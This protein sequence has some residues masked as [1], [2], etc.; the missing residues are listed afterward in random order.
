MKIVIVSAQIWKHI[1]QIYTLFFFF[2]SKFQWILFMMFEFTLALQNLN[3]GD[4][5]VTNLFDL[6]FIITL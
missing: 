1:C 3:F 6:C 2:F 5:R 4:L